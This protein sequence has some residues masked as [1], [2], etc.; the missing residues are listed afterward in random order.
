MRKTGIDPVWYLSSNELSYI[1]SMKMKISVILGV[2]HMALGIFLRGANHVHFSRKVDFI[3][4]FV[5]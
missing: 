2:L 3:F 1:N 4:E 5:P